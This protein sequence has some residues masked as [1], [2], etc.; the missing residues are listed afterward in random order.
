MLYKGTA[1]SDGYAI[2]KA[3]IIENI[4]FDIKKC[5]MKSYDEEIQKLNLAFTKAKADLEKLKAKTATEIDDSHAKIFDA[6]MQIV[7]DIEIIQMVKDRLQ[8]EQSCV[9]SIYQDVTNHFASMFEMMDNDYLKERAID[10]IDV[11]KRVLTYLLGKTPKELFLIDEDVIIVANDLTPSQIA[12]LNKLYIKGIATNLGGRTS[13]STIMARSLE[14]PTVVGLK[15]ITSVVHD[16]DLLILDGI[17]GE[18]I[19]S[20]TNTEI[21]I[22]TKTILEN[23]EQIQHLSVWKNIP[24]ITKDHHKIKLSANI[25][26]LDDLDN[27]INDGAEGV[28][29]LRTEFLFMQRDEL[30]SEEEQFQ[31]YKK[32]LETFPTH[33]VVI[34]TIDVGAD[35]LIRSIPFSTEI[36]PFLGYR[37]LRF[38]LR[39]PA[40]FMVQLRALLRASAVGHLCILFPM[41][42]TIEEIREAKAILKSV[43]HELMNEG[44]PIGVYQIGMMVEIPSVAILADRFIKEVDFFSIGTND[45]TQ[46]M[47]AADRMNDLVS[48]LYQP[49]HPALHRLIKNVIDVAHENQ[50]WVGLCGE[51]AGDSYASLLLLGLGL[52]EF[53]MT[54][55]S[56]LPIKKQF[57]KVNYCDI[58]ELAISLLNEDTNSDVFQKL[59]AFVNQLV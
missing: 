59:K 56:I 12:T 58:H 10:I 25:G 21:N 31:T 53:S 41:V 2:H 45:L 9:E 27:A 44:V 8:N 30:P 46:Y 5:P 29:L 47:F 14:I 40:I 37:S 15:T 38:C 48:Y 54:A 42:A 36:N 33:K 28:G 17:R 50:K 13:H 34:R 7:D 22:Y 1:A 32:I 55:S 57:S 39:E 52:D 24:S 11:Q 4:S 6:H 26:S 3:Y 20:P 51:I 49:Y 18:V 16:G 35:K 43:E 23:K 19:V